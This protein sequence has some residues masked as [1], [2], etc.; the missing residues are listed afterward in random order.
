MITK[1]RNSVVHTKEVK[2]KSYDMTSCV[3]TKTVLQVACFFAFLLI[4]SMVAGLLLNLV[5]ANLEPTREQEAVFDQ[6]VVEKFGSRMPVT[7]ED[8][9]KAD[10]AGETISRGNLK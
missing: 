2:S 1:I 7:I 8:I 4:F 6:A 3:F 9:T 10:A 5:G